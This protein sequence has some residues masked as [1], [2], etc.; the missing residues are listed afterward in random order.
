MLLRG[1]AEAQ[2]ELKAPT[3][4]EGERTHARKRSGGNPDGAVESRRS[5]RHF[6]RQASAKEQYLNINYTNFKYKPPRS[7]PRS[8]PD[9]D[10][11]RTERATQASD[12]GMGTWPPLDLSWPWR[13]RA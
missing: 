12:S 13:F 11:H 3:T 1:L 7:Q 6:T 9:I 8:H 2:S 10:S 5:R 4:R